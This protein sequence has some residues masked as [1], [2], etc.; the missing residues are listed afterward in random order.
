M[1]SFRNP[2]G[3]HRLETRHNPQGQVTEL[4]EQ[5]Y[6]PEADGSFSPLERTTR[7][8]YNDSGNLIEIDGPRENAEA[9][10]H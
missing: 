8:S 1:V 10:T 7:L 5:G 6:R 2:Q 4:T 9:M 3:E